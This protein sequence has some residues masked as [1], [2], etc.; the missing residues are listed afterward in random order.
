MIFRKRV[1]ESPR[2][3][4]FVPLTA[5]ILEETSSSPNKMRRLSSCGYVWRSSARK[6]EL[7][8]PLMVN[9]TELTVL[10][11]QPKIVD[12]PAVYQVLYT[13]FINKKCR[14][15]QSVPKNPALC[16]LCGQMLCSRENCTHQF[17]SHSICCGY[18]TGIFLNLPSSNVHL[19][20]DHKIAVWGSLYLD[21][22][23]EEDR[24]LSRGKPLFLSKSRVGQLCSEI[25]EHSFD[26]DTSLNWKRMDTNAL[27]L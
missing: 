21:S 22:Y 23:G 17:P 20:R 7:S 25:M 13:A 27:H 9:G 14:H 11:Y 26:I 10:L 24:F 15:C 18:G 19:L 8:I 12:L 16:L 1:D 4:I 5:Y 6:N 2:A 3:R